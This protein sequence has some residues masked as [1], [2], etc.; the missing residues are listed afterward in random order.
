MLAPFNH[1]MSVVFDLLLAPFGHT[2]AA[3]DLLVWPALAGIVALLVYKHVSNQAGITRAK[4]GIQVH[5]L[6]IVLYRD[7]LPGVIVSTVRALMQNVLYLGYNIV[8]MLVMFAPM[9]AVLVQIVSNY[10]YSPLESDKPVLIEVQMAESTAAAAQAVE[11]VVP[12]EVVVEAGP[13]STADGMVAWR[14][15]APDGDWNMSL[16]AGGET[17]AKGLAV[18]G[19][20][21]KLPIMRTNTWEALL[22]PGEAALPG[23]SAFETIR[24]RYPDRSLP[25]FPDGEAGILG[26][27]FVYSLLAGFALKD[28]FGVTL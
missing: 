22:Y 5:L 21:R 15:R 8:P 19:E 17:Q 23:D 12:P 25:L 1:F 16:T 14:V 20:P 4:N 6:E 2:F 3:F 27:F 10:A 7:D 28:R 18:G 11:L 13:V 26:W 24:V 9:T